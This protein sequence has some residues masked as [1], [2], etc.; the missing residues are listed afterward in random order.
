MCFSF[1][2]IAISCFG[3]MLMLFLAAFSDGLCALAKPCKPTVSSREH[4]SRY[5]SLSFDS[6]YTTKTYK[7]HKL[8]TSSKTKHIKHTFDSSK[9]SIATK[10]VNQPTNYYND[11]SMKTK[12]NNYSSENFSKSSK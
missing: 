1:A 4:A 9:H 2:T 11:L 7:D 12:N 6:Y 5:D 8:Q 10:K 3:D